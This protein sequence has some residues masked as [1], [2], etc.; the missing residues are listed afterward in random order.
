MAKYHLVI[1][2][3]IF[4]TACASSPKESAISGDKSRHSIN[5]PSPTLTEYICHSAQR[6]KGLSVG[7]GHCVSLIQ[8]C[9]DAPLT[10]AWK[11]GPLVKGAKLRPGTIIAIFKNGKYPN[12]KGWHAAIYISQNKEGIWVWDQWLGMPVHKRLIRFKQGVGT[13]NNDGD[14]YSIVH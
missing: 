5:K 3:L 13:A 9:S 8:T 4:L 10:S 6:Y 7:T 14:A 12:R 2:L 1:L 11:P